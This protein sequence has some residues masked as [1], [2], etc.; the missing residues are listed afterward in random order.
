MKAQ[1]Y[2]FCGGWCWSCCQ[3]LCLLP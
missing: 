2:L 3:M 1:W